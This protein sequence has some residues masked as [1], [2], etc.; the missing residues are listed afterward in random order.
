MQVNYTAKEV[1][2]NPTSYQMACLS[3]DT[4]ALIF[5]QEDTTA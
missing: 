2:Q 5:C 3:L 4:Y 1:I